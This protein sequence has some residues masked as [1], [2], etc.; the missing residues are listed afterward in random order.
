M[1]WY[2]QESRLSILSKDTGKFYKFDED[3]SSEW[4]KY[5]NWIYAFHKSLSD[6]MDE[7]KIYYERRLLE[8]DSSN[9]THKY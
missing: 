3:V 1:N 8:D 2:D 6:K 9:T 5:F 7:P 4:W